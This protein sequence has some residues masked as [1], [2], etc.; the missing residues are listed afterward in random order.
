[1]ELDLKSHIGA[2]PLTAHGILDIAKTQMDIV[3]AAAL[4]ALVH[5]QGGTFLTNPFV[6]VGISGAG[7]P[8]TITYDHAFKSATIPY[9]WA[10][11]L[12]QQVA[13]GI[14]DR[15][16]N[17]HFHASGKYF[18]LSNAAGTMLWFAIGE[19]A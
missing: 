2:S 14:T 13:I 17:A 11:A 12:E 3:V 8:W 18:D 10:I 19:K 6:Q 9:P 4:A 1:M 5:I 15:G 16:D 7:A